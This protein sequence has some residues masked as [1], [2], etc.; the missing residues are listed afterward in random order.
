[1]KRIKGKHQTLEDF[2]ARIA[3]IVGPRPAA[4]RP[5][6]LLVRGPGDQLTPAE[7]MAESEANDERSTN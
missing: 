4:E 2:K 7:T 6:R 5:G 3:R 1:M